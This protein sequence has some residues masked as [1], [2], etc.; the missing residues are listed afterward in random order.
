VLFAQVGVTANL[1]RRIGVPLA[2]AI[3]PLMYL[4][5]F[6]GLSVRFS[7]PAGIGAMAGTKLQ[8][9]AVYDPAVRVLFNLFP[10]EIRARAMVLLEGPVKRAGGAV[11]NVVTFAA[12]SLGSAAVVGY[13]ALPFT[14]VWLA[15]VL[16]LWRAYPSLLLQASATRSR[17]G[18][19]FDA[20]EML[21]A[22]TLR[23]L[24]AHLRDPDPAR[25]GI[26]VDLVS[27]ARP[28]LATGVL[29]EAARE[30]PD[31]TRPL[32]VAALDRVLERS[33]GSETA[34]AEAAAHL[35]AMLE[36][37]DRLG[38]RDRAD[39]VQAYGRVSQR[40]SRGLADSVLTR[41]VHDPSPAVRLTA[42]AALCR[43]GTPPSPD[44]DLDRALVGAIAA[45]DPVLRRAA[46]EEYRAMLLRDEPDE[47]WR[48]RLRHLA[49]LLETE[50]DRAEAAMAIADVA[51]RHGDAVAI[52]TDDMLRW[53][54]DPDVE[55][56]VAILGFI[57]A[58]GLEEHSAWLVSHARMDGAGEAERLW[59]AARGG[60]QSL[61]QR[62]VDA[63]LVELSFGKRSA[64]EAILP[65]LRALD[66]D[67]GALRELYER[68]L[69]S[70]RHKLVTLHA[71]VGAG[72]SPMLLQR[73]GERL[74]E[75]MHT[76][77]Q[78]LAAIHD[79]DR[80]A[81]LAAPLRRERGG[82]QH[83]ILLEALEALLS[84]VEKAQLMP[85]VED[86]TA[87]ERARAA[88]RALRIEIPSP[89]STARA[90]LDDPDA[91]TQRIAVA[92]L[93]AAGVEGLATDADVE[94]DGDVL[95]P[96]ERALMLKRIPLFEELTTRQLLNL[97]ELVNQE[98]HPPGTPICRIGDFSDCMYFIVDGTVDITTASDAS[99]AQLGPNDFFGEIAVF[100]G[101]TR[102]ANATTGEEAVR[103]L[104]LGRDDLLKLMEEL[105]GIAICICQTLSR[106]VRDLTTRLTV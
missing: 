25:C 21:D 106:R 1:Y 4:L 94:D 30:A 92:T 63:L 93:R 69:D 13:A 83:A 37:P 62:A 32:L 46:R 49:R 97:A 9:S 50:S 42:A 89:E 55:T 22:N 101:A 90:L 40:A 5:G 66:V 24:A 19:D 60:L 18:D 75:G 10:E 31:A 80:I 58:A 59:V 102:S 84:P 34:D 14:A 78:L 7:L 70:I 81:N 26:A 96:V 29:A 20:S 17:L 104:R 11:G 56:R 47:T 6:V 79:D 99:L 23:S 64:Q 41:A 36:E 12:V 68:E 44:F 72:V 76:A 16:L 48:L 35:Q 43:L 28:E 98:E 51:R 61:G 74:D 2:T 3:S 85:L 33:A 39:V 100:E 87:G 38:E 27:D 8:D 54:E 45:A 65:L 52:V 71:A 103:L 91:V 86:R 105:P 82:R 57:G 77:L 67:R 15:S 53:R 95:S 88:A 73:L